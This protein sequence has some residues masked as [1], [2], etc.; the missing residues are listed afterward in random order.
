MTRQDLQKIVTISD[1]ADLEKRLVRRFYLMISDS[2]KNQKES[3]S[4]QSPSEP[5]PPVNLKEFFSI[6]AFAE[7]LDI[8]RP[9]VYRWVNDGTIKAVQESGKGGR[10]VIPKSELERMMK[11]AEEIEPK[12]P[13]CK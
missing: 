8:S 11:T 6:K 9:T 10:W 13:S 2:L 5:S 4:G 12:Q 1:L 7:I 3:L